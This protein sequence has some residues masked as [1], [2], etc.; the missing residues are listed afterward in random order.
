M[1]HT[2]LLTRQP[3]APTFRKAGTCRM[4]AALKRDACMSPKG[5]FSPLSR[6]IRQQVAEERALAFW[7]VL[8]NAKMNRKKKYKEKQTYILVIIQL[9]IRINK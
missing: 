3:P 9:L 8:G 2:A 1:K 6:Q 4:K 5:E 7:F